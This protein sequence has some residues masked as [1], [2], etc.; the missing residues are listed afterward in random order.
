[1]AQ[2]VRAGADGEGG[3]AEGDA[4]DRGVIMSL[5]ILSADERLAEAKA[6]LLLRSSVKAAVAKQL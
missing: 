4:H 5:R 6:K 1:M 2:G 3:R